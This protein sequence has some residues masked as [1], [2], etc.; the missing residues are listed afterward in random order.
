MAERPDDG[1]LLDRYSRA[2]G[3][4]EHAGGW[5]WRNRALGP[6][7][8][9][10]LLH[11]AARPEAVHLL[12]RGAHPRFAGPGAGRRPRPAAARRADQPPR[13]RLARVARGLPHRPRRRGD[14][15]GPRQVVPGGRGHLGAGARGG[16]RSLLPRHLACL[17][18]RGGGARHPARQADR[19]A[20]GG[21]RPD[22]A[23][24][25][26]LPLQGD[27]GAPGAVARQAAGQD[28]ADRARPGG[29][30][31]AR[32]Q[33][34]RR[35]AHRARG[36]RADGRPARGAGPHA[37]RG[38]R[39]VARARRARVARGP[40][41]RRQDHPDR[42]ARGPPGARRR[43]APHRP[44]RPDRL[45]LAARR[46]ARLDAGRRSRRPSAPRGSRPTRRA[47]CSAGSC[48]AATRPRSRWTGCREASAAGCRWRSWSRPAPT[49]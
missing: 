23:V 28:G 25:R 21:D 27:E 35:R 30:P 3:R 10:R 6:P 43:Q 18:A 12:R 38:R 29:Q 5:D 39:A 41:R 14:P 36:A 48:S 26:A 34:R 33:L 31:L 20:A 32:V 16:P 46:G 49:C 19:E 4:L 9:A 8:R 45:P 44:Q 42:G 7:A 22:G 15:G 24:H 2:Q 1:T 11:R 13:H 47:P 40:E 17:A 37:R